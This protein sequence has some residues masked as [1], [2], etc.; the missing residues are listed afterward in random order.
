MST[1]VQVDDSKIILLV[2][3]WWV[4]HALLF[5]LLL[6]IDST[7][8]GGGAGMFLSVIIGDPVMVIII[9]FLN[10]LCWLTRKSI[11]EKAIILVIVAFSASLIV[12]YF[13]FLVLD[14]IP[15][16][17]IPLRVDGLFL[18][19]SIAIGLQKIKK[20]SYCIIISER[21]KY[22]IAIGLIS[23]L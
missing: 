7:T 17:L 5:L 3:Y 13:N 18:F 16:W 21:L 1:E 14:T 6:V 9:I 11:K 22:F 8:A 19:G 10:L 2:R 23:F 20:K 12:G 4:A 15:T